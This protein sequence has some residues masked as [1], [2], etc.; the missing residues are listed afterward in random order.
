MNEEKKKEIFYGKKLKCGKKTL[1]N[2]QVKHFHCTLLR[3]TP[4][5]LLNKKVLYLDLLS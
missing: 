1:N 4:L 3:L 5:A 2:F